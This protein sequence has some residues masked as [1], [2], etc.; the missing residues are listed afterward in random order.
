MFFPRPSNSQYFASQ[1]T[2]K[3]SVG[4]FNESLMMRCWS[5]R[6]SNVAN[7]Y[8]NRSTEVESLTITCHGPAPKGVEIIF[9]GPHWCLI[10]VCIPAPD[11]MLA[12]F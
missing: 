10:P 2:V 11:K 7:T 6:I 5:E 3:R 1:V 4:Q 8:L 9:T 12:P